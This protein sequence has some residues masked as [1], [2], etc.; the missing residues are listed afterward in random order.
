M[1]LEFSK[2]VKQLTIFILVSNKVYSLPYN[3][4][5]SEDNNLQEYHDHSHNHIDANENANYIP[6]NE[7]MDNKYYYNNREPAYLKDSENQ[8][9]YGDS[10][11]DFNSDADQAEYEDNAPLQLGKKNSKST[12]NIMLE[13]PKKDGVANDN[14]LEND[15]SYLSKNEL[16][17]NDIDYESEKA[18]NLE[19]AISKFRNSENNKIGSS[20]VVESN[21]DA[22]NSNR[23]LNSPENTVS[24]NKKINKSSLNENHIMDKKDQVQMINTPWSFLPISYLQYLGDEVVKSDIFSNGDKGNRTEH[25]LGSVLKNGFLKVKSIFNKKPQ[26]EKRDGVL[27]SSDISEFDD[28]LNDKEINEIEKKIAVLQVVRQ[29]NI[30][31]TPNPNIAVIPAAKPSQ[32]G[33]ATSTSPLTSKNAIITKNGV[34]VKVEKKIV[35]KTAAAVTVKVVAVPQ[36]TIISTPVPRNSRNFT[37]TAVQSL[38]QP[39]CSCICKLKNAI[40]SGELKLTGTPSHLK[41]DI[42]IPVLQ[43]PTQPTP[44]ARGVIAINISDSPVNAQIAPIAPNTQNIIAPVPIMTSVSPSV[45]STSTHTPIT[46]LSTANKNVAFIKNKNEE[47]V[48]VGSKTYGLIQTPSQTRIQSTPQIVAQAIPNIG[49]K[50]VIDLNARN[51]ILSGRVLLGISSQTATPTAINI[52]SPI[53]QN[54]MNN[55]AQ[56]N[57]LSYSAQGSS[58][59]AVESPPSAPPPAPIQAGAIP[60]PLA[61]DNSIFSESKNSL[62]NE[63]S[64]NTQNLDYKGKSVME[65]VNQVLENSG[66]IEKS[67]NDSDYRVFYANGEEYLEVNN[68]A[69]KEN[70][71]LGGGVIDYVE[72]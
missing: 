42:N 71:I 18:K 69:I 2:A 60:I 70:A 13:N 66:E 53:N 65:E 56:V 30:S 25:G 61:I 36:S 54:S 57:S 24:T 62:M 26:G 14:D 11:K 16:A 46:Q 9:I 7:N 20:G 21:S 59:L 29:S 68:S 31:P 41:T 45:V 8:E 5:D 49:S 35:V 28:Y 51:P 15:V 4:Y 63:G 43:N 39:T 50:T 38:E 22:K 3:G 34:A 47:M 12:I 6:Q 40:F 33:K 19:N 1:H 37:Q 48:I 55:L 44:Q 32:V 72:F 23:A 27:N 64:G 58:K 52:S 17:K 10:E 67:D